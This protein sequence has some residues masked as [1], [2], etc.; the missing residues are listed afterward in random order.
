MLCQWHL[1]TSYKTFVRHKKIRIRF[2]FLCFASVASI[3]IGKD[4]EYEINKNA[5]EQFGLSV[6]GPKEGTFNWVKVIAH[7]I[8]NFI[9]TFR[10]KFSHIKKN[11]YEH[12]RLSVQGP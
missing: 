7:W 4:D 11:I 5:Y 8:Q 1:H 3:F 10:P 6:Q 2:D 9:R 12:F